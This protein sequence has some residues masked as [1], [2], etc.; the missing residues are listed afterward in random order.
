LGRSLVSSVL[1]ATILIALGILGL[2]YVGDVKVNAAEVEQITV[3][4]S[5]ANRPISFRDRL[6]VGLQA[7]L[8]SE[9]AFVDL[10]VARVLAGQIPQ[11]VV[12]ETFFWARQRA[13]VNRA[14]RNRRPI[15]YFIPAMRARADRLRV[16]L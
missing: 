10:V 4:P 7:R 2:K 3:T 15:I 9:V 11:R 16:E 6:V 13:S 12:D 5:K 8:K 1:S 14:G